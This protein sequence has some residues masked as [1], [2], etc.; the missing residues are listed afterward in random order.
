MFNESQNCSSEDVYSL[1]DLHL[2]K[3]PKTLDPKTLKTFGFCLSQQMKHPCWPPA[4]EDSTPGFGNQ[5][6]EMRHQDSCY[7]HFANGDGISPAAALDVA[8]DKKPPPCQKLLQP[9]FHGEE[10]TKHSVAAAD[11]PVREQ[12][13]FDMDVESTCRILAKGMW[14][15]DKEALLRSLSVDVR[16]SYVCKVLKRQRNSDMASKFFNWAEVQPGFSHNSC[17]YHAMIGIL[18]KEKRYEDIE[19]LLKSMQKRDRKVTPEIYIGLA[20]CY[21]SAGLLEKAIEALNRLK[22]VGCKPSVAAYNSLIDALA[23]AGFRQK[24]LA[25]YKVMGQSRLQPDTYTFN[26]LMHAF[27]NTKDLDSVCKLFEEMRNQNCE[28]DVVTFSTLIDA[29][30]KAGEVDKAAFIFE[31]MK[32]RGCCPNVVTF[33]S[34]IHGMGKANHIDKALEL[35]EEMRTRGLVIS[36]VTYNT[37][38]YGLGISGRVHTALNLFKAMLER[39]LMPDVI[40]YSSLI[41]GLGMAGRAS[42]ARKLF[43][44]ARDRGH[45]VD[46]SIYNVLVDVLC[47]ADRLDEAWQVFGQMEGEDP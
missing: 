43:D 41:Q 23:K 14:G 46:G 44:E 40:T 3:L 10:S 28:P 24:A 22:D 2:R 11:A 5:A 37:L 25:V 27:K 6:L 20:R 13:T 18:G 12:Q 1:E 33:N 45:A 42:E 30:C 15:P 36:T 34:L 7:I 9:T 17:T 26:I 4:A 32:H 39:G 19:A 35:F 31:E 21:G 38:L 16:P 29:L 8:A 47:K